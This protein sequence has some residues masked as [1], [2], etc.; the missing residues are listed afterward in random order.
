[1]EDIANVKGRQGVIRPYAET[2][3]QHA[4]RTVAVDVAGVRIINAAAVQKV[5][6]IVT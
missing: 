4:R 5:V 2:W 3:T 6:S 1:M